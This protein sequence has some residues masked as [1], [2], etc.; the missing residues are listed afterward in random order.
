MDFVLSFNANEKTT[1]IT[2]RVNPMNNII[3]SLLSVENA[4]TRSF[5][6]G[7]VTVNYAQNTAV[8]NNITERVYL[9][10]SAYIGKFKVVRTIFG[11]ILL[12]ALQI[13]T[14]KHFKYFGRFRY[15]VRCYLD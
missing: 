10:I 7:R 9:I 12:S 8:T 6:S 13:V 1:A 3:E 4:Q 14:E 2:I 5:P 15:V 11:N